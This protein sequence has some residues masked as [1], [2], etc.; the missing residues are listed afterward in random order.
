MVIGHDSSCG[1]KKNSVQVL[2]EKNQR[3]GMILL[4]TKRTQKITPA[5]S[6]VPSLLHSMHIILMAIAMA[7][8]RLLLLGVK[9]YGFPIVAMKKECGR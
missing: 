5:R 2:F 1:V 6:R 3:N 7:G 9:L 8:T 4:P